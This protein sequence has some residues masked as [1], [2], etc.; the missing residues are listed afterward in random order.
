MRSICNAFNEWLPIS[1]MPMLICN[2]FNEWLPIRGMPMLICNA[3]NVISE[4]LLNACLLERCL[5]IRG[6]PAY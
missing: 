1:G 2:A 4:W 6:M 5:P 3:F